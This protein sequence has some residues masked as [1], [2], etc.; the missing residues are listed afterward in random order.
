MAPDP[1]KDNP[2]EN[3][4]VEQ[5]EAQLRL[6]RELLAGLI[7]KRAKCDEDAVILTEER[8]SCAFGAHTG[9]DVA[10]RRLASI[11]KQFTALKLD[12]ESIA[13][14]IVESHLRVSMA[15]QALRDAIAVTNGVKA[16]ELITPLLRTGATIDL[17]IGQ[18]VQ[19]V[20]QFRSEVR[21]LRSL[22][23][24]PA[25]EEAMR[26]AIRR[27]LEAAFAG[28][29]EVP[30][31]RPD[32]RRSFGDIARLWTENVRNVIRSHVPQEV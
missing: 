29:L 25:S 6:D 15:E 16:L 11:N 19:G 21:Q 8:E 5:A 30:S 27:A 22:G 2:L 18:V 14:A 32:A 17:A 1:T 12:E 4:T 20:A 13:A 9:D 7:T 3:P 24:H 31:Q 10:R 26:S 23:A 28:E